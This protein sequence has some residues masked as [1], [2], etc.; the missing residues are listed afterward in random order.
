[1]VT[2]ERIHKIALDTAK[3]FIIPRLEACDKPN[4]M[5]FPNLSS[6]ST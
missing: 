6:L 2:K 3:A 1:M 5:G 4:K